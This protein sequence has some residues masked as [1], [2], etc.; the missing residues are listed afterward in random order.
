MSNSELSKDFNLGLANQELNLNA[1]KILP[2]SQTDLEEIDKIKSLDIEKCKLEKDQCEM[3]KLEEVY[4][5]DK[6]NDTVVEA[7]LNTTFAPNL[8]QDTIAKDENLKNF[9]LI[10]VSEENPAIAFE[11]KNDILNFETDLNRSLSENVDKTSVLKDSDRLESIIEDTQSSAPVNES[12]N[13]VIN[14]QPS[15]IDSSSIVN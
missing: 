6:L 10:N 11:S 3:K 8:S 12:V 13:S 4:V 2:I 14:L 15:N 9:D 7:I 1:L 5:D